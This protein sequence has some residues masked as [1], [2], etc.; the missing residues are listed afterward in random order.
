MAGLI[1]HQNIERGTTGLHGDFFAWIGV[2]ARASFY[3]LIYLDT[4]AFFYLK[5]TDD[6]CLSFSEVCIRASVHVE[7]PVTSA[8]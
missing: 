8:T 3:P 2:Y 7:R 1:V 4:D 5:G 6:A